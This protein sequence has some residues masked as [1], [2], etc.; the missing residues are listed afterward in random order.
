MHYIDGR[1]PRG[2][3]HKRLCDMIRADFK[4]LNLCNE[5]A[6][7]REVWRRAIKLKKLIQ[8]AGFPPTHVDSEHFSTLTLL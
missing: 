1:E 5:N 8:H 6:N 4:S 2:C 7:N 3:P